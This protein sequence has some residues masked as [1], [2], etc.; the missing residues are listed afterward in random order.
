MRELYIGDDIIYRAGVKELRLADIK[1]SLELNK[2]GSLEFV[3]PPSHPYYDKM[4]KLKTYIDLYDNSEFIWRFRVMNT[5][6]DFYKQRSVSC[7]GELSVLLDSIQRPYEHQGSIKNF[8]QKV[9]DVHNSQV[10][11]SKKFTL[12]M[13]NVVDA[14]NYINRSNGNYSTTLETINDKLIKTHGGYIRIRVDDRTRYLDYISDYGNE[15]SQVIRFGDNMLDLSNYIKSEEL[16][17]AIIPLG[18]ELGE[19]GINGVKKRVDIKSVND[20]KDYI[21]SEAAV[22]LF[23]WIWD[24]VVFDDVTLPSNLKTKAQAYLDECI[25]LQVSLELTAID[26]SL[27][28]ADIE[29]I[30]LG[31]W[32][33]VISDPHGLNKKFLVSKLDYDIESPENDKMVLGS[34]FSTFTSNTS[35]SNMEISKRVE[36]ISSDVNQNIN[37]AVENATQLI[38]GGL[39]GYLVIKQSDDGHP[40]GILIMDTPD[41]ESAKNIIQL[42]KNGLGFSTSG[43]NGPYKNAWTIDGRLLADFITAGTLRGIRI[44]NGNNF[45]VDADGNVSA[46]GLKATNA[47]I[48]GKISGST[49]TGTLFD[50]GTIRTNDGDIGGWSINSNGLYNGTVKI[51]NSGITNIYTWA[52][53]Y[54]IRLIIMGT[55]DADDDMVYHYDF[56]G[57]GKITPADYATLKNR[58]K[59]M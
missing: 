31:D 35:K 4:N 9:L 54:I 44:T 6:D 7:E 39:G 33:Q 34:T 37:L 30:K 14:N 28:N 18:A 13:C 46:N 38:T 2:S 43:I 20:N 56:N 23:G 3:M 53:L 55:V 47:E 41:I 36:A 59:A 40:E 12:G 50:G 1:I 16:R 57:D 8:L 5:E 27:L 32:I 49:I 11:E 17:T 51:K 48:T 42:N 45:N 25:N 29:K 24:T 22:Q 15:C 26:M 10:E 58:L 52:D 19:D 21:Y